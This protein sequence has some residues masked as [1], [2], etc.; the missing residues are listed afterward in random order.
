VE[1]FLQN[2]ANVDG[3]IDAKGLAVLAM[4]WQN[5][6]VR[7]D[8]KFGF[9]AAEIAR[10]GLVARMAK[11]LK[12]VRAAGG[13]V[14]Y[15]NVA[16]TPGA[17]DVIKNSPVFI[18]S[19]KVGAFLKGSKGY[20]VI[21]ELRPEPDEFQVDHPRISAFF[22]NQLDILLRALDIRT[23]AIA[24]TATNVAVDT[25]VR[26]ALQLGYHT[27]LIEDCCCSS[28]PDFHDAA[29]KTLRV[30][31]TWVASAEEFLARLAPATADSDA[32]G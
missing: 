6:L 27:I 25:S 18:T 11:V 20:E 3:K 12:A 14:I 28:S 17:R 8:G 19:S 16:R 13:T 2:K 30:L 7:A 32:N 26:D 15:I 29:M 10:L 22:G 4:H 9:F 24:G 21:D 1:L 31:A 5:D 23:V